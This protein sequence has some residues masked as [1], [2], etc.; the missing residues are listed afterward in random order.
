M[1]CF[2]TKENSKKT[3][4]EFGQYPR[5]PTPVLPA[6]YNHMEKLS[7]TTFAQDSILETKQATSINLQMQ[8]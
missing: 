1:H 6:K 8:M 4:M 3:K 2:I 5:Y 7:R